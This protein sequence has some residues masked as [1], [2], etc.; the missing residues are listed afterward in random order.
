MKKQSSKPEPPTR[1]AGANT[2][3]LQAAKADS[4]ILTCDHRDAPFEHWPRPTELQLAE[5]AARLARTEKIDPKQ[6]VAEAWSL[7]WESCKKIQQ[8]HLAVERMLK[9]LEARDDEAS[10]EEQG[11]LPK[12]DKFPITFTEMERMLLP[13]LKGRTGERAAVFREY[14]FSELA[15]QC[16]VL[17][18]Q[19]R[20]ASYWDFAPA[21]L[22]KLREILRDNIARKFGELRKAVYDAVAYERFAIPFLKWYSQ[23]T[24][25]RRSQVKA[26]N[27][28][29]GWAKR[30]DEKKAKTGARPKK[31]LLREILEGPAPKNAQPGA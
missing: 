3:P 5:L 26:E 27:A 19:F 29:K 17:R 13:K 8:D 6:L 11:D 1:T 23:W 2:K 9:E 12:P 15:G 30:K 10:I 18:P 25:H 31:K 14:V 7:Y 16:I 4:L 22:D 24:T 20:T 28:R 21:D